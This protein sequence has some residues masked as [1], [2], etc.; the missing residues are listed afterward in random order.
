ME[1]MSRSSSK[2]KDDTPPFLHIANLI[3]PWLTPQE[4]SSLSCTCHT[5]SHLCKLISTVRSSDASRSFETHPI[6]FINTV[7][8]RP[9][10]FFLY[11]PTQLISPNFSRQFWGFPAN[12]NPTLNFN[13]KLSLDFG[14]NGCDCGEK[15]EIH[16]DCPCSLLRYG[17]GAQVITEC[18]LSCDCDSSCLNRVTQNGISVKLKIVRVTKKGW[19]LFADQFISS[20]EF[21]CE[22]A[23]ELLTTHEARRRHQLYDELAKGGQ[24][25]SALLVVREYLPSRKAC[26]RINID[27]TIMG[28]VS[29]FINHSCDGGNLTTV[30]VR[31]SGAVMPRVC[32]FTSRDVQAGEELS[33]SYGNVRLQPQGF[34]CLCGCPTC[35]GIL[36]SEP[37]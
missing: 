15:C 36:P 18:G 25:S 6:P 12:P 26:F 29:R 33:F 2:C 35:F 27:A 9:Y 21:V 30:L 23:G 8:S 11:T 14:G 17:D 19:G 24:F 3:I 32:F 1:K 16:D 28:N 31:S 20:G 7:D 13:F 34:P 22:Y 4:L 10:A 5:L 37:T